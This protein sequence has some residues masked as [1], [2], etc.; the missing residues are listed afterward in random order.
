MATTY[1][2]SLP[3]FTFSL[4]EGTNIPPPPQ[5]PPRP[6]TPGRGPLSSH[7]TT[8]V[9]LPGAFPSFSAAFEQHQQSQ[10]QRNLKNPRDSE[11]MAREHALDGLN[12]GGHG[13]TTGS[14]GSG[15]LLSPTGSVGSRGPPPFKR[16]A[17]VRK[18]LSLRSL[19]IISNSQASPGAVVSTSPSATDGRPGSPWTTSSTHT[20]SSKVSFLRR[21]T[22][23]FS[24]ARRRSSR[25]WGFG[26]ALESPLEHKENDFVVPTGLPPPSLPSLNTFQN[27][28]FN[29]DGG[30]LGAD[31]MFKH[32]K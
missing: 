2:L 28:N 22:A 19:N 30:N 12:G 32:I 24:T 1:Q 29:L 3:D 31:D 16:P 6:P 20:S 13:G 10:P 8:P 25:M 14:G 21:K 9:H 27:G 17:S 7:P 26:E 15:A 18:F 4:T 11:E 5:E 23:W